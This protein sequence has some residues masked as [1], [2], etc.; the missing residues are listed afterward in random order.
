[1]NIGKYVQMYSEDL[2]LKNYGDL[3]I[4]NY[5]S[6]VKLFLEYFDK[7]ATKPSEIN[8]KQIAWIISPLATPF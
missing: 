2:H 8:E 7:K 1:M 4:K 5:T 3:T 6:Q